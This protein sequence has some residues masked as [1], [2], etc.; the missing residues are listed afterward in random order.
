VGGS[1]PITPGAVAM[2]ADTQRCRLGRA[3]DRDRPAPRP[4]HQGKQMSAAVPDALQ[5]GSPAPSA[6]TAREE[7]PGQLAKRVPR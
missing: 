7:A 3:G 5:P 1:S 2:R 6:E 4:H